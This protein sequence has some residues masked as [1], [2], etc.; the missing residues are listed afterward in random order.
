MYICFYINEIN[1]NNDTRDRRKE[2]ELFCYCKL[3][4]LSVKGLISLE[5]LGLILNVYLKPLDKQLNVG[6][7]EAQLCLLRKKIKKII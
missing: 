6:R 5:V 7:K 1:G 4:I 3:L 2:L